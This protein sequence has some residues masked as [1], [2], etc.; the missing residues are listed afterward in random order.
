[1]FFRDVDPRFPRVFFFFGDGSALSGAFQAGWAHLN[2]CPHSQGS[3]AGFSGNSGRD[4]AFPGLP[5]E[6][7]ILPGAGPGTGIPGIPFL[8]VL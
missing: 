8:K 4:P 2:P 3:P 6:L 1:M 7:L 5:M